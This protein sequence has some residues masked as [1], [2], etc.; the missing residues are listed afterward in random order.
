[1]NPSIAAYFDDIESLLISNGTVNSFRVTSRQVSLTDGKYRVKLTLVD[2]SAAE[3]FVY[4]MESGGQIVVK[5]YSF[6][7]QNPDGVLL[8]R[9]DNAPHHPNLPGK[10]H[11]VHL[12]DGTID[13]M[14]NVPDTIFVLSQIEKQIK[15]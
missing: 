4:V 10:P 15:Q 14:S 12:P 1:M 11:H 9:W 3:F 5:K 7:W 13:G 6:H 2:G 8:R